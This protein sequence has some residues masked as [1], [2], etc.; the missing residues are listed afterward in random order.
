[1][2]YLLVLPQSSC[3]PSYACRRPCTRATPPLVCMQT[4]VHARDISGNDA[5]RACMP[6]ITLMGALADVTRIARDECTLH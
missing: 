6:L 1:M 5:M 3:P 2:S 4:T